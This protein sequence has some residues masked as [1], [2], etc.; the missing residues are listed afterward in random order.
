MVGDLSTNQPQGDAIHAGKVQELET[1]IE[2]CIRPRGWTVAKWN[3]FFSWFPEGRISSNIEGS[4]GHCGAIEPQKDKFL[5]AFNVQRMILGYSIKAFNGRWSD[6]GDPA[7]P[8][9]QKNGR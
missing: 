5:T 2:L 3:K 4:D 1:Q 8:A 6:C 9:S 7:E